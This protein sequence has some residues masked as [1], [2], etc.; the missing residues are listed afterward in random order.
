MA[1]DVKNG[2]LIAANSILNVHEYNERLEKNL[3]DVG[4]TCIHSLVTALQEGEVEKFVIHG[5]DNNIWAV[6]ITPETYASMRG[7]TNLR[8]GAQGS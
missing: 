1:V 4:D 7:V 3:E 2:E 8:D 5:Q 6:L